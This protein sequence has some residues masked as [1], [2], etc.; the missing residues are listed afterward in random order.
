MPAAGRGIAPGGR[1]ATAEPA[2]RTE[3]AA[4]PAG[5]AE[6]TDPEEGA[7]LPR[8]S[9]LSCHV[10]FPKAGPGRRPPAGEMP[11]RW[12]KCDCI[13][14][15]TG[16]P[17]QSSRGGEG[18]GHCG[19]RCSGGAVVAGRSDESRIAE[20]PRRRKAQLRDSAQ[21]CLDCLSVRSLRSRA[22]RG[23]SARCRQWPLPGV[24]Y[25]NQ[26]IQMI[27]KKKKS[28]KIS[29]VICSIL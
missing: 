12:K 21:P 1:A 29:P 24:T 3:P 25:V 26:V 23:G 15:S 11:P 18:G 14:S 6:R 22:I 2:R 5:A 20:S 19:S 17:A 4:H 8:A 16:R 10:W 13:F 9:G 27:V 28:K 7:C